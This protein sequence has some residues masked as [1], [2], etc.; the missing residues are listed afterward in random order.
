MRT[1][2]RAG[3]EGIG[4]RRRSGEED[5]EVE[6]GE[7]EG[8]EEGDGEVEGG[9]EEDG[10]EEEGREDG[11]GG[12]K[13]VG[14]ERMGRRRKVEWMGM[15]RRGMHCPLCT[16][17]RFR[18]AT[19]LHSQGLGLSRALS[20]PRGQGRGEDA[21]RRGSTPAP[22]SEAGSQHVNPVPWRSPCVLHDRPDPVSEACHECC[23]DDGDRVGGRDERVGTWRSA[24]PS[25]YTGAGR[26]RAG[27]GGDQSCV[28]KVVG[29]PG[30]LLRTPWGV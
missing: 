18:R 6:D 13:R 3:R 29:D 11:D 14:R 24:C 8:R 10:E 30:R 15:G 28:H 19:G 9:E 12:S 25:C 26:E 21:G 16:L 4:R 23:S 7:E 27:H 1:R 5:G 2:R 20:S 17:H 22:G